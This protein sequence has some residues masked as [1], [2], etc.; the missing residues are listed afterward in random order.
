M[1]FEFKP[2]KINYSRVLSTKKRQDIDI[3]AELKKIVQQELKA[4]LKATIEKM[5]L[6]K[7]KD[8]DGNPLV[9]E[10]KTKGT[11]MDEKQEQMS[12]DQAVADVL[13]NGKFTTGILKSLF[14][15]VPNLI[16]R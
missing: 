5:D 4:S 2:E 14:G 10:Q 8:D 7:E 3:K 16:G 6:F 12:I 15:L 11:A 13:M 9:P 1:A